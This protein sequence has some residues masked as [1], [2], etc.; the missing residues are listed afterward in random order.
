MRSAL[1][2]ENSTL[3]LDNLYE[4]TAT[5]TNIGTKRALHPLHAI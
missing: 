4:K 5:G 2:L 1:G 3:F